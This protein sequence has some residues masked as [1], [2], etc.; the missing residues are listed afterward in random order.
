MTA[1]GGGN[2]LWSVLAKLDVSSFEEGGET[3]DSIKD[4]FT[5]MA[6]EIPG[7]GTALKAVGSV[8]NDVMKAFETLGGGIPA[9]VGSLGLLT[10]ALGALGI[11]AAF[12]FDEQLIQ[13]NALATAFGISADQASILSKAAQEAGGSLQGA[14][15]TAEKLNT[16][17]Y[18]ANDVIK[19]T[20]GAFTELGINIYG[21]NGQFKSNDEVMTQLIA[22]YNEGG[23]TVADYAAFQK[24]LGKNFEEQIPVIQR[25]QEANQVVMDQYQQGIGI[26]KESITDSQNLAHAQLEATGVLNQMGSKLV[27]LVIPAFTELVKWFTQSYEQ[28]GFV[29][30]AFVVVAGATELLIDIFRAFVGVGDIVL[31]LF[32]DLQKALGGTAAA[33]TVFVTDGPKAAAAVFHE[34]VTDISKDLSNL[35]DRQ[36]A[37]GAKI[38]GAWK[39]IGGMWNA[40]K[41][42]GTTPDQLQKPNANPLNRGSDGGD[43]QTNTGEQAIE[44]LIETLK[45][46]EM[47]QEQLNEVQKVGQELQDKMYN[48]ASNASRA[49]ALQLAAQVDSDTT[50]KMLTKDQDSLTQEVKKFADSLGLSTDKT[51]MDKFQKA[52]LAETEKINLQVEKQLND[53]REHNLL[54]EDAENQLMA[55]KKAAIDAVNDSVN[56]AKASEDNWLGRGV[57]QYV[58]GIS[59]MNETLTKFVNSSLSSFSQALT[60]IFTGKGLDGMKQWFVTFLN[61]IANM[62]IQTQILLPLLK[63]MQSSGWTSGA[64][65]AIGSL[66]SSSKGAGTAMGDV[67]DNGNMGLNPAGGDT[68]ESGPEADLPLSKNAAGQL[69]VLVNGIAGGGSSTFI[70]A[71]TIH[72]TVNGDASDQDTHQRMA[73][74]I[75][76]TMDH[77][78]NEL[79]QAANRPG[80]QNNNRSLQF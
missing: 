80:G 7:V 46:Q 13:L 40:Q 59:N 37:A 69:G 62:I 57:Q 9:V 66:F 58:T 24:I 54:T 76:A 5:E 49:L 44:R 72:I 35:E 68:G 19:G 70:S 3:I 74:E 15:A 8:S 78:W 18:R 56:K 67:Y 16:S 43:P 75:V 14:I 71:P 33:F 48:G 53:L 39:K 79:T 26:T 65:S 25:V 10:V 1:V 55:Q 61:N 60:G 4:K 30:K 23:L 38:D 64:S 41:G 27:E 51:Q 11:A 47:A 32:K 42:V 20:G 28:G 52:Q 63:S 34:M 45:K 17:M 21:A 77:R 2:T 29:A 6:S 36:E 22:R 73:K 31:T 50:T 12:K